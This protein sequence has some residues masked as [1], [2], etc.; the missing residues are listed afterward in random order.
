M[1]EQSS[2]GTDII[3]RLVIASHSTYNTES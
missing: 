2:Q 1:V 3:L